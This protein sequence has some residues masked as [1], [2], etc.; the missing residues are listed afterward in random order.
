MLDARHPDPAGCAGRVDNTM[1]QAILKL[2]RSAIDVGEEWDP[3]ERGRERPGM[4]LWGRDDPYAKP[5]RG[6]R[7]AAA[8]NARFEV[9]DGGHW[10]IFEHPGDT[11]HL[12]E[13][14]WANA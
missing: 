13:E 6:E 3:G 11:A 12:L 7:A 9:L 1:K 10:A 8:A 14:H 2:Y 4:I 5:E